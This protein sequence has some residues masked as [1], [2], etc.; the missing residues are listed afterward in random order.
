MVCMI[1]SAPEWSQFRLRRNFCSRLGS[2]C[3][4]HKGNV[5]VL[6]STAQFSDFDLCPV[7]PVCGAASLTLLPFTSTNASRLFSFLFFFFETESHS[8]AQA[9]V[10][11]QVSAQCNL[12]LPGSSNSPASVSQIAEITDARHHTW[13]I[14]VFLIETCFRHVGQ[15]GLKLL[16]SGVRAA[17]ATSAAVWARAATQRH[18][19]KII[20]WFGCPVK[21]AIGDFRRQ[22]STFI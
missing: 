6:E 4:I 5:S 2:C 14:F 8:V 19:M 13:L 7:S 11:W 17:W 18:S 1:I 15:A 3:F 9:G 22:I 12:G 16:I 20:H 21:P 10:Q